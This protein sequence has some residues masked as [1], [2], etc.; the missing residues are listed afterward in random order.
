N[1][2]SLGLREILVGCEV[3][4]SAALLL[5]AGLLVTSLLRLQTVDRGF[6]AERALAV[7]L[8]L[9]RALYPEA[10]D[11]AGFFDRA[12]TS[13]RDLPGVRRAAFIS[14][15]PL[16]GESEVNEV[17]LEG[18]ASEALDPPSRQPIL[19][20]VRFV[21]PGYFETLGIPHRRG[22]GVE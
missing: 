6:R 18:A 5:L 12:L 13:L 21:S 1:R 3:G 20:N 19:L 15:L 16:Q 2:R 14:K 11:R 17:Q 8:R 10:K 7:D 4:V 22:R 9:P